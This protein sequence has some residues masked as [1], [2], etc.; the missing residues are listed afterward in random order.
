[1]IGYLKCN[2][3]I[4][5]LESTIEPKNNKKILQERTSNQE[6]PF[7]EFWRILGNAEENKALEIRVVSLECLAA[8]DK[9]SKIL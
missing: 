2:L 9:Q 1:M 6:Y 4:F 7:I 5:L 3:H 8:M